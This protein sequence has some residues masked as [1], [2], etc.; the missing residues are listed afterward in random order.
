M[1]SSLRRVNYKAEGQGLE[2]R[3]NHVP[4]DRSSGAQPLGMSWAIRQK[5]DVSNHATVNSGPRDGHVPYGRRSRSRTTGQPRSTV[6]AVY[7]DRKHPP[8]GVALRAKEGQSRGRKSRIW[9]KWSQMEMLSDSSK[10]RAVTIY[11]T[12]S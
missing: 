4:H 10:E 12:I 6:M 7:L 11:V 3:Y 9:H 2:P 1:A 8:P 5:V